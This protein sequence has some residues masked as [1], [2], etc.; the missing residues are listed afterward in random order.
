VAVHLDDR[1]VHV[2]ERVPAGVA[3]PRQAW[4]QAD[5]PGQREQEPRRDR[6]Q[7]AHVP[8]GERAQE[9]PERRRRVRPGEDPAHPAVPQQR[10]VI[11]RVGA[12]DHP[13]HQRGHLQPGMRALVGRH[14]QMLIGQAPQS[15]PVGQRQHRDQPCGRHE[16]RVVEGH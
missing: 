15:R 10:H 4:S 11:D 3:G 13:R 6:V 5:Q 16:I 8:E 1:V 12:G 2:E 7:L 14:T 9:R